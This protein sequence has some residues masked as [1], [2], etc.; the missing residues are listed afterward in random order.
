MPKVEERV[1]RLEKV[2][3]ELATAH[4][5]FVREMKDFKDEMADFKDEMKDFKDEMADFKDEMREFKDEM[6]DFKDEMREFKDEM[7]EFKESMRLTVE[8]LS[9]EMADFKDEMREFKDEMADFKSETLEF[10]R[11]SEKDRREMNKRWGELA[12][13]M[14][15][16]VEDIVAPNI[17]RI[18]KEYFGC[19]EKDIMDVS[20]RRRVSNKKDPSLKREFDIVAVCGNKVVIN[21]TKSTPKIEYVNRFKKT[22]SEVYDYFPEYK[23]KELIGIFASLSIREDIVQYLTRQGIYAM[24]MKD[25]T[26]EILNPELLEGKET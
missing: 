10:Q 25:D 26:M 7:R 20:I 4:T 15:T 21:E 3:E 16:I 22:L 19:D 1:D 9:S 2:M 23:G 5:E 17:P 11:N 14:G 6:A 24:G 18:L 8:N 13:K 12:N